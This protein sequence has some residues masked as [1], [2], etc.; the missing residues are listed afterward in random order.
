MFQ[1]K[2]SMFSDPDSR[3]SFM[4]KGWSKWDLYSWNLRTQNDSSILQGC[5]DKQG[6]HCGDSDKYKKILDFILK[7]VESHC[8]ILSMEV[9]V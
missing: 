4:L 5:I 2:H 1:G 6:S 3:Y 8:I 7:L 9:E